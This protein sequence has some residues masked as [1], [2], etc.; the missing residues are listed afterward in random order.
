MKQGLPTMIQDYCRTQ[1][2]LR[3]MTHGRLEPEPEHLE[4]GRL[5]RKALKRLCA[6]FTNMKLSLIV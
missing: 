3:S 5:T 4:A 2:F 1:N 6:N